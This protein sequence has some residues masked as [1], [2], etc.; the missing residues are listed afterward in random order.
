MF[1][2]LPINLFYERAGGWH[3]RTFYC[4]LNIKTKGRSQVLNS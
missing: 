4:G 3:S 2:D 1:S